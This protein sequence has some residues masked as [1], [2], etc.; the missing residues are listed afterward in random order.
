MRLIIWTAEAVGNLRSIF[1]YVSA[2]NA[3]AAAR[4]ARRL[5]TAAD[6]LAD[7]PDRG[8]EAS[9]GLR[10]LAVIHPDLIRYRVRDD[11]VII[12]RIRHGARQNG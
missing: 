1:G 6:S 8:R 5:Q 10:E 3:P 11:A 2:F 4:L 9:G 7:H 12:L